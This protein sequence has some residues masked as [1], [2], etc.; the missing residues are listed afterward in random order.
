MYTNKIWEEI[1]RAF[2]QADDIDFAYPTQRFYSNY[3]EGK[4]KTRPPENQ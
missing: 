3:R 4:S 2:A 1:L